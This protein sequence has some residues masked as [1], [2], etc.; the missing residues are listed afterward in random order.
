[1][2]R[3]CTTVA[4]CITACA[5][6]PA[7]IRPCGTSTTG[8][9]RPRAAYAVIDAEVF[10][11]EA[12]TTACAPSASATE[13]ATVMPRSLNEP[14]GLSPSTLSQTDAPVSS[15]SQPD[16]TR[17]VPPSP[18]VTTGVVSS[19]G[20]QARY[21]SITPRHCRAPVRTA[22][23]PGAVIPGPPRRA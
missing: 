21:S 2:P 13:I 20:N 6:L 12:Q 9:N 19:T 16:S 4:P 17:G 3:T 23:L 18:R 1:L 7:A 15:D 5:I 14:V 10:P 11:V 22:S 8:R